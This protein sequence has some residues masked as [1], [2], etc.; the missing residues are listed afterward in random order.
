RV[1][2]WYRVDPADRGV[3][4]SDALLGADGR[5]AFV[6]LNRRWS[7]QGGP[8]YAVAVD[9]A[10]GRWR[11]LGSVQSAVEGVGLLERC[12]FLT[13]LYAPQPFFLCWRLDHDAQAVVGAELWDGRTGVPLADCPDRRIPDA[14]RD[15]VAA[16][17]RDTTPF[18]LP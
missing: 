1:W 17:S 5:T 15:D 16:A 2:A 14:F 3:T 4:L 7:R 18:H 11:Q 13:G 12:E 8:L 9:L 10:S 6:T